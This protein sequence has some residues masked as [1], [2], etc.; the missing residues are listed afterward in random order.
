M[1]DIEKAIGLLKTIYKKSCKEV[2][3][4]LKG[5]FVNHD[6]PV[7]ASIDL[8]IQALQERLG[9]EKEDLNKN[10]INKHI[11]SLINAMDEQLANTI[12]DRGLEFVLIALQEKLDREK[13]KE[14]RTIKPGDYVKHLPSGEEWVVC[15]VNHEYDFLIPC[16]FPFPSMVDISDCVLTESCNKPQSEEYKQALTKHGLV[17]FIER[18]G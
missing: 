10:D 3:G 18:E 11:K 14:R 13:E 5:G 8:A 9:R 16:G 12:R 7:N 6:D 15:G 4:R 2:D 17:S 1:N